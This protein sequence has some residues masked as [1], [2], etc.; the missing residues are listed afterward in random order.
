MPTNVLALLPRNLA[1]EVG[2]LVSGIANGLV[3]GYAASL[4][5]RSLASHV[6]S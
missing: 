1:L 4:I 5:W 6:G 2:I 3:G